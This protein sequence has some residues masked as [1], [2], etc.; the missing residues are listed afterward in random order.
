MGN[1][2]SIDK[3]KNKGLQKK[4][5]VYIIFI[6]IL[7]YIFYSIYLLIKTPN[8]TVVVEKRSINTRRNNSPVTF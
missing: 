3:L 2:I 7:I 6:A 4:N 8:E 5:I 1:I